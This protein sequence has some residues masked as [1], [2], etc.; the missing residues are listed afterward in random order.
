MSVTMTTN[1]TDSIGPISL[2]GLVFV[3]WLLAS[4]SSSLELKE[5][6]RILIEINPVME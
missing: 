5:R 6:N 1:I 3:S 2:A 4:F